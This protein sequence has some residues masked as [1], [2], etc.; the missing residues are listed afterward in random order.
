[1]KHLLNVFGFGVGLLGVIWVQP[2]AGQGSSSC[3]CKSRGSGGFLRINDGI[4]MVQVSNMGGTGARGLPRNAPASGTGGHIGFAAQT[5]DDA[6]PN[7]TDHCGKVT[8][9][10]MVPSL[11]YIQAMFKPSTGNLSEYIDKCNYANLNWQNLITTLPSGNIK[12]LD[13]SLLPNNVAQDGTAYAPPSFLDPPNGG[14]PTSS[15]KAFPF[16]YENVASTFVQGAA[17]TIQTNKEHC[18]SNNAPYFGACP[19]YGLLLPYNFPYVVDPTGTILSFVDAPSNPALRGVPAA[20]N[21]PAGTFAAYQTTLVA[22]SGTQNPGSAP[23]GGANGEYCTPLY[24]FTWNST[25]NGHACF[26]GVGNFGLCNGSG[27]S[28]QG[29]QQQ[30]IYP[31]TL[32]SGF[33]GVTITGINGVPFPPAVPAGQLS[34]TASG[35][36]YS[37]VT[38][39]FD[40]TVTVNNISSAAISGPIQIVLFGI[41]D[42]VTLANETSDLSG[43]PYI[44]V[45]DSTT[46]APGQSVTVNVQFQNPSDATID[47]TPVIYAGSLN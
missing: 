42:G 37:R 10:P 41:T 17:C 30:G 31:V 45:P 25:A 6:S 44:T 26:Q 32:G 28:Q 20:T 24:S 43:T 21:P 35:L 47:F 8:V 33:S 22:V 38:Q 34:T 27:V 14:W 29:P 40:G 23:C 9:S 18:C 7:T 16:Y 5:V 1:M 36:A 15:P 13:P 11:P 12:P 19:T 4:R 2:A 46:L 39:T 3:T